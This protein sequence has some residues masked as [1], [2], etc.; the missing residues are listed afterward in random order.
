MSKKKKGTNGIENG[1][2]TEESIHQIEM[3]LTELSIENETL[4]DRIE[5]LEEESAAHKDTI[6]RKAAEFEN[7]K[8]RTQK[9]RI[10]V[11]DEAKIGAIKD[12]LPVYDDLERMLG[13]VKESEKN[14]FVEG[15]ELIRN[16]FRNVLEQ[17]GV[18]RIDETDVP[19]D[20]DIHDAMLRQN[21]GDETI[22]SDTVLQVLESGYKI[23]DRVI[24]HA[25]VIVSE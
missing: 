22:E 11:F 4:R 25:K 14:S 17:A 20:V 16:K 10:Q 2:H 21:A 12:F 19:F 8:K 23:G 3:Q 5:Q 9:E 24:R 15:V 6:L 7:L 13:A 1:S 18:E